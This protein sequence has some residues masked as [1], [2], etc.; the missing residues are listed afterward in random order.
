M[1][2]EYVN[3]VTEY[4]TLVESINSEHFSSESGHHVKQDGHPLYRGQSKDFALLPKIARC[5]DSP[6]IEKKEDFLLSELKIHARLHKN[7]SNLDIWG[8]MTLG[9]HYGLETRLLDWTSNPLVA[10]WFASSELIDNAE[11]HVYILLPHWG[12]NTLDRD[13]LVTTKE[14]SGVSILRTRLEDTRVIAQDAFFTVH[15][16]SRKYSK[17]IPLGELEHH[18]EGMA[19]I[20]INPENKIQILKDLN[21]LGINHQTIFPDLTGAC[22][23]LNWKFKN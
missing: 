8:L 5:L 14:H 10:I 1:R 7:I 19:K 13:S 17:F 2:T 20:R 12:I 6:N 22:E 9:Q 3:T 23:Y 15:S 11:P 21:T 4:L 16:S 18:A